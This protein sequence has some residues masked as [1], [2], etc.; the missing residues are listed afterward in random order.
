MKRKLTFLLLC[1]GLSLCLLTGCGGPK[2]KLRGLVSE[3]NESC[4]I[5]LGAIGQMEGVSYKRNEVT[6]RYALVGID[7]L[8]NFR[9]RKEEFHR[10]MLDSYR[11]NLNDA[12]RQLFGT[13]V[14]AEAGLVVVMNIESGDTF[15]LYF[16]PEQL[17]A[18]M[19]EEEGDPESYLQE[20]VRSEQ[21]KLPIT[22]GFGDGMVCSNIELDT[23]YYTYYIDCDEEQLD[24]REMQQSIEE[25]YDEMVEMLVSS[26]DPSFVKLMQML[27]ATGRGLRYFYTGTTSGKEAV[28]VVSTD[29]L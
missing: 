22:D 14:E 12:F 3:L 1:C 19:P 4:P 2:S 27:K 15:S 29:A 26:S 8:D 16:T 6:F 7:N 24:L 17:K 11:N 23:A 5:P 9:N 20:S 28:F 25:N 13:I 21:F 18:N 10:F